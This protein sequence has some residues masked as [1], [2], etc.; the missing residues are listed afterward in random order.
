MAGRAVLTGI[1]DS[2]IDYEVVYTVLDPSSDLYAAIHQQ[3]LLELIRQM[4]AAGHDFAFPTRTLHV[5]PPE[6]PAP[7]AAA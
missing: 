5:I 4:R 3:I 2:S 6:P 1:G 7:F